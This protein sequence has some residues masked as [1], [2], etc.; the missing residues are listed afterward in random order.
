MQVYQTLNPRCFPTL[1]DASRYVQRVRMVI[2]SQ[3]W[4]SNILLKKKVSCTSRIHLQSSFLW[5]KLQ[6]PGATHIQ[7]MFLFA[8]QL[9]FPKPKVFLS[10]LFFSFQARRLLFNFQNGA[11]NAS[12]MKPYLCNP[13]LFPTHT[14]HRMRPVWPNHMGHFC[15][16]AFHKTLYLFVDSCFFPY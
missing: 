6:S 16:T 11:P 13:Y 12:S 14:K 10:F 5:S 15:K 9:Y 4:G 3:P 2:F 1:P 7:H 8:F